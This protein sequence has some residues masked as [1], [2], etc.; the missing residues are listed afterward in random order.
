MTDQASRRDIAALAI[1]ERT[2]HETINPGADYLVRL[3]RA[4]FS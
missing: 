3:N 1:A 2:G 4:L